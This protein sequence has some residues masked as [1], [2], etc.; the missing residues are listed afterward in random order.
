MA[1]EK[2][3]LFTCLVSQVASA[4]PGSRWPSL[5]YAGDLEV[6][7]LSH[8]GVR[9]SAPCMYKQQNDADLF[10]FNRA[11]TF[12][13]VWSLHLTLLFSV[14]W[15]W[16]AVGRC[17]MPSSKTPSTDTQLLGIPLWSDKHSKDLAEVFWMLSGRVIMVKSK[18]V[19][20]WPW[21]WKM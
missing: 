5:R 1:I 3:L 2:D 12:F 15:W 19:Q 6:P 11:C 17:E 7:T 20:T 9:C 4:L 16:N 14:E 13:F 10:G 8:A 18:D 21:V